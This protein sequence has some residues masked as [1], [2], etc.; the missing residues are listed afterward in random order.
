MLA[1]LIQLVDWV[2]ELKLS[3]YSHS[4]CG[5]GRQQDA[6]RA[7]E[8]NLPLI[9]RL[10]LDVQPPVSG[11][12]SCCKNGLGQLPWPMVLFPD[13]YPLAVGHTGVLYKE[14]QL[15]LGSYFYSVCT[16]IQRDS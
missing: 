10:V 13:I 14:S 2:T 3:G 1:T 7:S 15:K 16:L 5:Q 12:R 11:K 9:S 6:P 8:Q 4:V